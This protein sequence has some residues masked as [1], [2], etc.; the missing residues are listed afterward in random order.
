[1]VYLGEHAADR[2][3]GGAL[4][5]GVRGTGERRSLGRSDR[6]RRRVRRP[7]DLGLGPSRGAEAFLR[8]VRSLLEVTGDVGWATDDVL[9]VRSDAVLLRQTNFGTVRAGGGA[10]E[11]PYLLLSIFGADGLLTRLEQFD[12]GH[13]AE[14]LAHEALARFDLAARLLGGPPGFTGWRRREGVEPFVALTDDH[15][16]LKCGASRAAWPRSSAN[17]ERRCALRSALNPTTAYVRDGH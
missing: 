13:E 4:G 17:P 14:A 16:V 2:L 15:A 10:Y 1:M 5:R 6:A 3:G 9:V 11:R 8:G 7:P 12:V